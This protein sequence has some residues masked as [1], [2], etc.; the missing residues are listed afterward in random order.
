MAEQDWSA[1]SGSR[2][3]DEK[4]TNGRHVLRMRCTGLVLG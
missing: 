3:R 1:Q 4:A 2:V